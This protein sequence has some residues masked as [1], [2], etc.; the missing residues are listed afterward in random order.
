MSR[1]TL[2]TIGYE[3]APLDAFLDTLKGAGVTLLVDTRERAQSR[4]RGYSKTALSEALQEQGIGYRHLRALGT[5]PAIRKAYKLDRDFAALTAGYTLHLATQQS[6]LEELGHLAAQEHVALL[7]YERNP[8]ECH[9][10]L[11][12][13]R[14]QDMGLVGGVEDLMV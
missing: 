7:C 11:I 13:R 3:D 14:L 4:R 5:P 9:R 8:G 6:A 10:S 1:P 2:H 12:A